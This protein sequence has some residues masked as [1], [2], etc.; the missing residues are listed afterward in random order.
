MQSAYEWYKIESFSNISFGWYCC[1]DFI[2]FNSE[3]WNCK[4][5][6]SWS[7]APSVNGDL[8]LNIVYFDCKNCLYI[9]IH[10]IVLRALPDTLHKAK[11]QTWILGSPPRLL[12][13][14]SQ[15]TFFIAIFATEI[16]KVWTWYRKQ[17]RE[18]RSVVRLPSYVPFTKYNSGTN[19]RI[20]CFDH[21]LKSRE[22]MKMLILWF[23]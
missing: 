22:N 14:V 15:A 2:V 5:W 11:I 20:S 9:P 3:S 23:S 6:F 18:M 17:I 21:T 8:L 12:H 1:Y 10:S 19:S 7:I 16:L 13:F 4:F